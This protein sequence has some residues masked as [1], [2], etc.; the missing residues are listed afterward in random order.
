VFTNGISALNGMTSDATKPKSEEN[1]VRDQ[2]DD[3]FHN[4]VK[5][6]VAIQ[7]LK[8]MTTLSHY[9]RYIANCGNCVRR[10]LT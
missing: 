3:L 4:I 8:R 6:A 7:A 10:E 2:I 9:S 5:A 1:I